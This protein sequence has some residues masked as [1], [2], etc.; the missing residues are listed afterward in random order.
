MSEDLKLDQEREAF[1]TVRAPHSKQTRVTECSSLEVVPC[2]ARRSV[3]AD[4]AG[5]RRCRHFR[6][7]EQR[8]G[9]PCEGDPGGLSLSPPRCPQVRVISAAH[10]AKRTVAK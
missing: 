8:S 4:P 5:P 7:K 9:H 1:L 2:Q 10:A 6:R 3:W